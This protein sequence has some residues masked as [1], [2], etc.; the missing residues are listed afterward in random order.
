MVGEGRAKTSKSWHANRVPK[1]PARGIML[2]PG[3]N[4][5]NG[6]YMSG[7]MDGIRSFFLLLKQA[8]RV[9]LYLKYL[10]RYQQ[11][12]GPMLMLS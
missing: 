9:F 1:R 4:C 8:K 6:L 7:S 3:G 10:I 5:Q 2:W 12:E 11:A